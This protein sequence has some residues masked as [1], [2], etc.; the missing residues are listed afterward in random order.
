M[1]LAYN[2][3]REQLPP[4]VIHQ[5]Q[6]IQSLIEELEAIA[7]YD[8]RAA[9]TADPALK[10]VIEHNRDEEM[11]HASML[12]EWLRR[13]NPTLSEKLKTFLFTSGDITAI[14]RAAEAAETLSEAADVPK[15]AASAPA[16]RP[17]AGGNGH[18]N[19]GSLKGA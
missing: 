16:G 8:Q 5:F 4:G 1:A 6:A 7:W 12:L 17:K 10:A 3:P 11:E 19:I 13:S 9:V 15:D 2:E 14:A 18:L